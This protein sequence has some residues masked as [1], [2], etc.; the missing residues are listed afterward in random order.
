MTDV[1]RRCAACGNRTRFDVYETVQRR[2]FAHFALGGDMTV[3][4]E[5]ILAAAVERVGCH[6]CDRDDAIETLRRAGE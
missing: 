3:A 5:E 4:D 2:R 1:V 6:W